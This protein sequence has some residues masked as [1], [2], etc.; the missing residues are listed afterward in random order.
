MA[1]RERRGDR[2][3]KRER[4]GERGKERRASDGC[5]IG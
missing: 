3:E 5:R 2:E 4:R 1:G